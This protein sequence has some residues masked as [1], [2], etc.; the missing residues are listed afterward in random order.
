MPDL[1]DEADG[2]ELA[3]AARLGVHEL[4]ELGLGE[5]I[6]AAGRQA[7]KLHSAT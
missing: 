7:E 6:D 3:G 2:V 1:A 4:G 5:A